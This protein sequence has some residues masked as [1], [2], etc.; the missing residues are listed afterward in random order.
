M[1][2]SGPSRAGDETKAIRVHYWASARAASGTDAESVV[3]SEPISLA[4]LIKLLV[5][6][7]PESNL[8]DVLH[9]CSVLRGDE[10]VKNRDPASV[11][12][13]PGQSIEFLPP[14]AGG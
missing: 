14:F 7:H 1:D 3:V 9:A 6:R 4:E 12:V 5:D 2:A 8:V 10:P 11:E 13:R